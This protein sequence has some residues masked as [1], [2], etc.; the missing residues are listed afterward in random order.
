MSYVSIG[1]LRPIDGIE[2]VYS[3]EISNFLKEQILKLEY[4]VHE[5]VKECK[6]FNMLIREKYGEK[7]GS[8]RDDEES[9]QRKDE[10]A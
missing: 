2:D 6:T 3:I 8:T 10:E 9:P 7:R 5:W 4:T 1:E